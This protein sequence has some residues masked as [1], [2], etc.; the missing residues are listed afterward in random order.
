MA[1]YGKTVSAEWLLLTGH[2]PIPYLMP[3]CRPSPFPQIGLL[4]HPPNT[5]IAKC[6][7]TA[8]DSDMVTI[9]SL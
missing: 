9:D 4:T 3:L 7:Q 5:C 6:G 2:F 8:A 1:R